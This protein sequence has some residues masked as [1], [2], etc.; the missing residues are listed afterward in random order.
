MYFRYVVR[1]RDVRLGLELGFFQRAYMV[2]NNEIESPSWIRA[3][4]WDELGWIN[5]NLD[6]P[7]RFGRRGGRR[8]RIEGICW[9][10]PEAGEAIKRA[11][12]VAWL[13]SE[14]SVP[15]EELR[16]EDPGEIIWRDDQQVVAK[17]PKDL[18]RAF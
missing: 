4:L 3:I 17:P 15:V 1:D 14:A 7:E 2:R 8:G 5:L 18:R 10:R 12:Y 11:R 6:V 9:F 16:R 13:M